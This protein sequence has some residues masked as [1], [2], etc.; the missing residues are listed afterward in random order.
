V[1]PL[2]GILSSIAARFYDMG[3][4]PSKPQEN[5]NGSGNE[6]TPL[7]PRMERGAEGEGEPTA[8]RVKRWFSHN[9]VLVFMTLL[10][11]AV[12]IILCVFFGGKPW[13]RPRRPRSFIFDGSGCTIE[14]GGP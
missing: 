11:A 14:I 4:S 6:R 12:I 2:A 5:G 7:L 13:P 1:I 3:V 9:A 10:V 8:K